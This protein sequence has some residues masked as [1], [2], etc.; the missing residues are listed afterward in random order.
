[1]VKHGCCGGKERGVQ[2][3]QEGG[4]RQRKRAFH[5]FICGAAQ[6][7]GWPGRCVWMG[8]SSESERQKHVVCYSGRVTGM[9]AVGRSTAGWGEKEDGKL[10]RTQECGHLE[11]ALDIQVCNIMACINRPA[12]RQV[13]VDPAV[14]GGRP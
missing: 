10:S 6:L 12:D 5:G 11:P 8:D 9:G 1:M 14:R 2:C 3:T 4:Q 13:W 7:A